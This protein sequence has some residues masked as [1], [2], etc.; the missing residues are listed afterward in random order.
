MTLS[1]QDVHYRFART[2]FG[3]SPTKG[4]SIDGTVDDGILY[5][6]NITNWWGSPGAMSG[7]SDHLVSDCLA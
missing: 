4:R 5:R 6:T 1:I 2:G 7:M 3:G